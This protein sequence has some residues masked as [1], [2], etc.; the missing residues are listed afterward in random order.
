RA[1]G[2]D[3]VAADLHRRRAA[4]RVRHAQI[5][6]ADKQPLLAVENLCVD[7]GPSRVVDHVSFTVDAGE[8]FALVGE[9]GSGKSVTA[10]SILRLATDANVSGA[11]LFNGED[12][13]AKSRR[14]MRGIRGNEIAM[15]FQEPMTALNP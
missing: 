12:L 14:A 13:L 9:S 4:R 11:V 10:L 15:I 2:A 6:S 7:F 8:K 5:M 1:A 3:L